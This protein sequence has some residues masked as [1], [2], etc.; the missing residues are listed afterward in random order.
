MSHDDDD[1][2]DDDDNDDDDDDD[3]DDDCDENYEKYFDDFNPRLTKGG[4]YYGHS[5][6][7]FSLPPQNP[8]ESD[9]S[10]LGNLNYILFAVILT[11]QNLGVP[12]Q[13]R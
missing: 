9:Q 3:D 5:L 1:D 13:V 11:K 7:N 10:H 4:G 8:R 12:L 2:D 6:E